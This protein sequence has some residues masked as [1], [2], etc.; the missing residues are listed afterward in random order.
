MIRLTIDMRIIKKKKKQAFSN[1][2]KQNFLRCV[3]GV[4]RCDMTCGERPQCAGVIVF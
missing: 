1:E 2:K 3:N 4:C